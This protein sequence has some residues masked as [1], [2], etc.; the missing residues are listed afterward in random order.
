MSR[1]IILVVLAAT[2][3]ALFWLVRRPR[4]VFEV[5]VAQDRVDVRGFV[6]NREQRELR[7]YVSALRLPVGA[8]ILA[9]ADRGSPDLRL[10]FS[11][12]VRHEDRDRVRA[13]L[14]DPGPHLN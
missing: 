5:R 3:A 12:S 1:I 4:R 6:P 10:R 13:F 2:A 7:D 8:R 14:R 9:V 11:S